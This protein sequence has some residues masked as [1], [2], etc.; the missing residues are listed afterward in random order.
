MQSSSQELLEAVNN[1]AGFDGE[2]SLGTAVKYAQEL[3]NL[4]NNVNN[5][6][7]LSHKRSDHT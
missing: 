3:A 6:L 5:G 2:S 1:L 4:F 7:V